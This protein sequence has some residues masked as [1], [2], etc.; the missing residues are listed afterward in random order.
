MGYKLSIIDRLSFEMKT[1]LCI[2]GMRRSLSLWIELFCRI[3]Y[4]V[5]HKISNDSLREGAKNSANFVY[6]ANADFSVV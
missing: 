4:A 3:T 6:K 2:S 5:D 1:P